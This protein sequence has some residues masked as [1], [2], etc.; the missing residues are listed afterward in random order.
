MRKVYPSELR[1]FAEDG[2]DL[3]GQIW[4]DHIVVADHPQEFTAGLSI[5]PADM[6]VDPVSDRLMN[7]ADSL[8]RW[9][10]TV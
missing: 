2:E 7:D 6:D 8:V 3:L 5:E 9:N 4:R 10:R 1:L